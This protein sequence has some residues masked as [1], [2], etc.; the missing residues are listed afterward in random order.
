[1]TQ[2][3]TQAFTLIALLAVL[4]LIAISAAMLLPALSKAKLKAQGVHCIN[5]LHQL[6]L[7][8]MLYADDFDGKL[9][10]NGGVGSCA[11]SMTDPDPA[12]PGGLRIN[13]GNWVHGLMGGLGF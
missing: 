10:R 3:K 9:P 8:W 2:K 13:N 4:A 7:G 12:S 1:M 11:T 6:T 5:N